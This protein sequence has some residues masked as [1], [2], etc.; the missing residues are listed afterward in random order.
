MAFVASSRRKKSAAKRT[1]R[2]PISGAGPSA[3]ST[4]TLRPATATA[5]P[6]RFEIDI[7]EGH[8]PGKVNMNI[9]NW[10]GQHWAR[11]EQWISPDDL[12]KDFHVYG[13]EWNE[14]EL[15][16]YIDGVVRR[17]SRNEVCHGEVPVIFSTAILRWAGEITDALDGTSMD[18]GYVRV[19]ERAGPNP[20][21]PKEISSGQ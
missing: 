13:L 12:S 14:R 16:W 7:N 15:I 3:R 20:A 11:H 6:G 19:Y 4:A 17:V 21:A 18:V 10:S 1:G 5:P 2:Q 8:H 9:H